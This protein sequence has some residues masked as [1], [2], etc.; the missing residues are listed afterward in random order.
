MRVRWAVLCLGLGL[1]LFT[2]SPSQADAIRPLNVAV[3]GG[4][5]GP[6]VLG[7]EALEHF[8]QYDVSF[9]LGLPWSW[10]SESGWGV[11]TRLMTS[12]GALNGGGDTAFLTTLVPGVF[13]G[14][15]D[16][17]LSLDL[18]GGPALLSRREFGSQDF[19]GLFQFVLTFGLTVPVPFTKTWGV[20][21]R[22]HHLSDGG[23]Y[24]SGKGVDVHML[25]V[26]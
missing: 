6:P 16:S 8:Q 24:H 7:G 3:R 5:T 26:T 12:V 19:G 18:G 9:T 23:I 15:R 1:G 21:Y 20:G 14:P 13:F 25:E 17:V 2:P 4:V 22:F 11:G 10:H